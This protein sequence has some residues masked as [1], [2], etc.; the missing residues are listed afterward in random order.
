[1]RLEMVQWLL[2]KRD[3]VHHKDEAELLRQELN[4]VDQEFKHF[5][6]PILFVNTPRREKIKQFTKAQEDRLDNWTFNFNTISQEDARLLAQVFDKKDTID[7]IMQVYDGIK[8]YDDNGIRRLADF[9][10][11]YVNVINGERCTTYQP[12]NYEQSIYIYGSCTARGTGC[13]DKDT[14]AS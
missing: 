14:V 7:Y 4:K 10:S 9:T 6:I 8:V 11:K 1:M 12:E 5:Q 2:E 3:I 13:E